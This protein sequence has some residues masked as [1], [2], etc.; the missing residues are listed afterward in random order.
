[1]ADIEK[2]FLMISVERDQ[3]VLR[4]L[5]VDNIEDDEIK[6]QPLQFTRAVFGVVR[7]HSC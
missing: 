5:C 3:D 4:F 6:I 7:V 1:M 2:A